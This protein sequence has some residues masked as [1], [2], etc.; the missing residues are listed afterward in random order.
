LPVYDVAAL[1]E[2]LETDSRQIDNLLSRNEIAGVDR[3]A[4]GVT[5]R[6][7]LD[8][9]ITIRIALELSRVLQV[10]SAHALRV[11][12]RLAA[13]GL[14]GFAIGSHGTLQFDLAELRVSTLERLDS[15]VE[16]VGR[17]SRGRPATKRARPVR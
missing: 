5:R 15:A 8:A 3:R 17:R 9:A 16:T 1:A 11:A 12:A 2:A 14:A 7:A 4:R 6:V 10:P 13:D